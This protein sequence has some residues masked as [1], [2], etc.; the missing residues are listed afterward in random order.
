MKQAVKNASNFF[1]LVR[2]QFRFSI[3]SIQVD[4][5]SEFMAEFQKIY[6]IYGVPLFVL[7]PWRPQYNRNVERMNGTTRNEFYTL[8]STASRLHIIRNKLQK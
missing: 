1:E 3:L 2:Q 8:Y 4:G 5:G 6:M 7:P